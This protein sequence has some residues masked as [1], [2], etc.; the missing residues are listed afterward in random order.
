MR[1]DFSPILYRDSSEWASAGS[2]AIS[3]ATAGLALGPIGAAVGGLIGGGIGYL[4]GASQK[5]KANQLL[6][7]NQYHPLGVPREALENQQIARNQAL[8]GLP[9]QQYNQAMKNIQR[10]QQ[11]ALQSAQD[12]RSGIGLIGSIQQGSNDAIGNLDVAD[13]NARLQNQR[14][15]IGVNNQTAGYKTQEWDR[16]ELN[17]QRNYEYGQQLLGAANVNQFGALDSGLAA[18]TNL[19]GR[20]LFGGNNRTQNPL[21]TGA[22]TGGNPYNTGV[23]TGNYRTPNVQ[24]GS[25]NPL[26]LS[27]T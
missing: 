24:A 13:A 22:G 2:G 16:N 27:F 15:L 1:I 7:A 23:D 26:N 8:Q 6:S 5:R 14:Q 9:S 25:L 11:Q 3:G 21:R 10:Q 4:E 18:I 17:R 12:R 20:G 19:T